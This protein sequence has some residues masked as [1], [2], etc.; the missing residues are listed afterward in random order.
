M[1]TCDDQGMCWTR[2]ISHLLFPN[3]YSE[4]EKSLFDYLLH[5]DSGYSS[6]KQ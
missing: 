1:N 2:P 4:G 3:Y 6:R 5:L